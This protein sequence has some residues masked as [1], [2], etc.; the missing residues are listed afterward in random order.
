MRERSTPRNRMTI[1]WPP[2]TD[3]LVLRPFNLD[4]ADFVLAMFN[5]PSFIRFI[6]DR[7]V[8]TLEDA[9]AYIVERFLGFYDGDGIGPWVA[10]LRSTGMPIGFFSLFRRDWL[11]DVDLGFALLP[12]HRSNGYAAEGARAMIAFAR[13][14]VGLE[15]LVAIV[16]T[17]NEAS[18]RLLD[19]LGFKRDQV[20][21]SPGESTDLL[22]FVTRL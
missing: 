2:E 22:L 11:D 20:V 10:E 5:D 4:D 9:E 15:R 16:S 21:R 14:T 17:G 8:R 6:G 7:E 13:D 19:R 3:R 18:I 1:P 12:G